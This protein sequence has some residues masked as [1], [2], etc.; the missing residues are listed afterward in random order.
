MRLFPKRGG[1]VIRSKKIIHRVLE[2]ISDK[3][4]ISRIYKEFEELRKA[5]NAV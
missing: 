1:N 2:N 3:G 4:F 5:N